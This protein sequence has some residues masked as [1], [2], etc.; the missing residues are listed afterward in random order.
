MTPR[1]LFAII[2]KII[3]IYLILGAIVSIP[4]MITTLYSLGSQ[5]SYRDSKDTFL[6]GFFLIVTVAFYILVMRY[7]VFRTDWL[8]DK[9]HL[10][11]GFIEEKL[12]INIHRSTTLNITVIVI[13]SLMVID[14]LP[15]L[16]KEV[17]TYSQMS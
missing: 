16:C 2:L 6:I 8:I 17:F 9:L 14:N 15:L 7:C 3:G 5:V 1:S 11:K 4:Q 10:D 13:G 12:E